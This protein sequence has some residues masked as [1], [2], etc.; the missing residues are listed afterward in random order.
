MDFEA[1]AHQDVVDDLELAMAPQWA[2]ALRFKILDARKTA[3]TKSFPERSTRP[4]AKYGISV[5]D[6]LMFPGQSEIDKLQKYCDHEY[7]DLPGYKLYEYCKH[8]SKLN[9]RL[10]TIT[11]M[12]K[13]QG[14][15]LYELMKRDPASS[16][17]TLKHDWVDD[18]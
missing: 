15:E 1:W 16:Q 7:P 4:E 10:D 3:W 17:M 2:R 11:I 14:D 12:P 9:Y 18:P 5:V 6:E 13:M 8:C